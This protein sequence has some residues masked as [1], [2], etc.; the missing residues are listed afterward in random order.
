[1][2]EQ[3]SS[4]TVAEKPESPPASRRRSAWARY[5]VTALVVLYGLATLAVWAAFYFG[6][7]R[8]WLATVMLFG[9]RWVYAIP[10]PFLALMAAITSRRLLLVLAALAVVHVVP[11][12]GFHASWTGPAQNRPV[13]RVM[14]FNVDAW[15]VD[16]K[17]LA[18][19]IHEFQP[20]VVALQEYP[21]PGA[22]RITGRKIDLTW[23]QG[24]QVV[25]SDEFLLATRLQIVDWEHFEV[26]ERRGSVS[27]I[28]YTLERKGEKLR[29]FNLHLLSPRP[30]L[31]A[32]LSRR[33]VL[34]PAE[35]GKLVEVI[36]VR[37]AESQALRDWVAAATLPTIVA[38][39]FNMP[40]D[41][42]IYRRDWSELSDAFSQSGFGF[43]YTK[44]MVK[45]GCQYGARIDH[46]LFGPDWRAC[47]CWVGPDLGSD[48]LPLIADLQLQQ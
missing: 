23:P 26:P 34:D 7:D 33:T 15:R 12:M 32:V 41:S 30:G 42:T 37:A 31:E 43:G 10:L 8:W 4:P 1:M 24:W 3:P 29:F 20:D 21:H 35:S 44:V 36:Q 40:C 28:A 5:T 38:G 9:P 27:G 16:G 18:E 45:W 22:I 2:S 11:I 13:L 48:H 6:G 19:F 39:D 14:S 47:R 17:R 25:H 46:V